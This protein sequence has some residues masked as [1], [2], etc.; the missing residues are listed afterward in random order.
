MRGP[1][2]TSPRQNRCP[3]NLVTGSFNKE[4][5]CRVL[6]TVSITLAAALALGLTAA[7]Y[8]GLG[9]RREARF[10][11]E[12]KGFDPMDDCRPVR[13]GL[14]QEWPC[15][16]PWSL[17]CFDRSRCSVNGSD[18]GVLSVYVH[19][20]E[21][22]MSRSSEIIAGFTGEK[23]R[24]ASDRMAKGLRMDGGIGKVSLWVHFGLVFRQT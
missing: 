19:S 17:P 7:T 20:E 13:S 1:L 18:F 15:G 2:S 9:F 10:P 24:D 16:S 3:N 11:C 22:S 14:D 23:T 8:K 6:K 5:I 12:G 4:F 21:C